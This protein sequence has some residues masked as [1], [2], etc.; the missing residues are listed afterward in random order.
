MIK[1]WA[2]TAIFIHIAKQRNVNKTHTSAKE[3][4]GISN[5]INNHK[6]KTITKAM[7]ECVLYK[8]LNKLSPV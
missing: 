7:I 6:S 2:L 4:L 3:Q 8:F 1:L 5:N